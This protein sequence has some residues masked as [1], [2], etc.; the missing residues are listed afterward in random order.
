M[1]ENRIASG[2]VLLPLLL[3]VF[4]QTSYANPVDIVADIPATAKPKVLLIVVDDLG[5]MDIG[6]ARFNFY[7]HYL[8]SGLM[9]I[10]LALDHGVTI[11]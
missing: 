8:M 11:R 1:L 5:A 3:A 7:L 4:T 10:L 6:S 2:S 9:V